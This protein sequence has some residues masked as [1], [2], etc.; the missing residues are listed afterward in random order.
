MAIERKKRRRS[1]QVSIEL[2]TSPPVSITISV[3]KRSNGTF[4]ARKTI[5]SKPY[6]AYGKTEDEAAQNLILA[7]N[8][9]SSAESAPVQ[10]LLQVNASLTFGEWFDVWVSTY[11][12][13]GNKEAT[14][15]NYRTVAKIHILPRIGHIPLT[16]LKER[17]FM[18]MC[19]EISKTHSQATTSLALFI[20]R[21][22]LKTAVE[23]DILEKHPIKKF[24]VGRK[25]HRERIAL[26]ESEAST[27]L[28]VARM[29]RLYCAFLILIF[30][31]LRRNEL[32]GLKWDD[33]NLEE[34]W[35]RIARGLFKIPHN[36]D[37]LPYEFTAPKTP[38]S[39]RTVPIL[40][41]LITEL[42]AHKRRQEAEKAA[43]PYY[44]EQN[45]VF[46]RQ[47]G[48]PLYP[49][50]ISKQFKKLLKRA[51]LR[52]AKLHDLRRTCATIALNAGA[53]P[54]T[55]AELLGH[56]STRMVNE[57]YS[58]SNQ[59]DKVLAIQSIGSAIFTT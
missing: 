25:A 29:H 23:E 14:F 22:C 36:D 43:T 8:K 33:I 1:K 57:I 37:A 39:Y 18:L 49:D 59:K 35:L 24:S 58:V 6:C 53:T 47:N 32:L 20:C 54:R 10:E 48:L 28:E 42:N 15:V 16:D 40:P 12:K 11:L 38:T 2:Q 55:V 13:I 17:H 44:F 21:T 52:D 34:G 45:L 56:S 3:T 50:T 4:M 7:Y 9:P 27:F 51:G 5:Q 26:D 41:L 46:P 30:C 31:G 19:R